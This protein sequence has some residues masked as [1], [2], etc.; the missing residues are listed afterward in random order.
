MVGCSLFSSGTQ[1]LR[2]QELGPRGPGPRSRQ[3]QT[4]TL[5]TPVRRV[6]P[7][8]EGSAFYIDLDVGEYDKPYVYNGKKISKKELLKEVA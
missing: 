7:A 8:K 1:E 3:A 5:T 2:N 4:T 6:W